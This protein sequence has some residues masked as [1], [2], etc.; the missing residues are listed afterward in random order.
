RPGF[1]SDRAVLLS[2]EP[3]MVCVAG[4]AAG[5][6]D[7]AG[8]LTRLW[9]RLD[10]SWRGAAADDDRR[11]VGADFRRGGAPGDACAAAVVADVA[12]G[13]RRDRY[14]QAWV[15]GR[16]RLVWNPDLWPAWRSGMGAMA[17]IAALRAA[18]SDGADF[19]GHAAG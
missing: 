6:L 14:A 5:A 9:R 16:A 10:G 1:A 12:A 19:Q 11:R 15:L 17:R 13:R 8:S 2:Q 18:R 4:T 3:A 7:L